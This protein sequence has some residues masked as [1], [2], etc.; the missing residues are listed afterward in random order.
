MQL[1]E[2]KPAPGPGE[3]P[4]EEAGVQAAVLVKQQVEAIRSKARSGSG[5]RRGFE[6]GQML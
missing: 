6:G 3:K 1:H 4:K 5:V 2:L